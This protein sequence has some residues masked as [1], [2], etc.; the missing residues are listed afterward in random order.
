MGG[1][2]N[3]AA[4]LN[5]IFEMTTET[6]NGMP[7]YQK[8]GDADTWLDMCKTKS[9]T[10]RWYIKPAKERGPDSSVCFGYGVSDNI[11]FPHE[12]DAKN[13]YCYDGH[14]FEKEEDISVSLVPG[15]SIPSHIMAMKSTKASEWKD[16]QGNQTEEVKS[17]RRN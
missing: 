10:W 1:T 5:G 14:K 16:E 3:R 13:W 4:R 7:M 11:V 8:K 15:S 6:C 9:G 12:C 17:W 2:G